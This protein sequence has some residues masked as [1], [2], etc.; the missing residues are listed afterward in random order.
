MILLFILGVIGITH[1]I[2]DGSIMQPFRNFCN[3][4]APEWFNELISCYQC[5]GF[6]VGVIFSIMFWGHDFGIS[7][8]YVH[9]IM[10]AFLC[11]GLGSFMAT[12]G[13]AVLNYLEAKSIVDLGDINE[14]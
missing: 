6:W 10:V 11:G 5:C 1:I 9:L 3:Q 13:A 2:V 4:Y 7:Y 8:F 14:S 12:C